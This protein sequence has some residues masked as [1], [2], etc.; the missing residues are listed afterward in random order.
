MKFVSFFA[1]VGALV[2][3]GCSSALLGTSRDVGQDSAIVGNALCFH[4]IPDTRRQASAG[5]RTE[6]CVTMTASESGLGIVES[7]LSKI[8]SSKLGRR[9]RFAINNFALSYSAIPFSG[10]PASPDTRATESVTEVA[11]S[12]ASFHEVSSCAHNEAIRWCRNGATIHWCTRSRCLWGPFACIIAR[13]LGWA[14]LDIACIALEFAFLLVLLPIADP[15]PKG[16]CSD[17]IALLDVAEG[18]RPSPLVAALAFAFSWAHH[19]EA[20]LAF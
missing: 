16:R 4:P 11:L 14:T 18:L 12:C 6:P 17:W 15:G 20:L 19:V 9:Q 1:G 13:D 5:L 3:I 2:A 10:L 7:T 8:H